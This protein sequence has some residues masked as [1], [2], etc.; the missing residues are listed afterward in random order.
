MLKIIYCSALYPQIAIPDAF[1]TSKVKCTIF[2]LKIR[3]IFFTKGNVLR[4]P[5]KINYFTPPRNLSCHSIRTVFSPFI[6]KCCSSMIAKSSIRP[7]LSDQS[8]RSVLS[9]KYC[10]T[11]ELEV[12]NV[13]QNVKHACNQNFSSRRSL[14]ETTKVYLVDNLRMPAAQSVLLFSQM[15]HCNKNF[16]T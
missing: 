1:N 11:C 6:H 16:T 4:R 3:S 15:V 2:N 5:S 14:L 10:V 7:A 12:E 13:L 8:Y 9:I